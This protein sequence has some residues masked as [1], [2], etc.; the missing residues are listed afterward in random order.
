MNSD[1]HTNSIAS[2]Q[3]FGTKLFQAIGKVKLFIAFLNQDYIDEVNGNKASDNCKLEFLHATRTKLANGAVLPVVL[4]AHSKD[5]RQWHGDIGMV[6]GELPFVDLS[7]ISATYNVEES[8]MLLQRL[9]TRIRSKLQST[10]LTTSVTTDSNTPQTA[11]STVMI[12]AIESAEDTPR[13]EPTRRIDTPTNAR[14]VRKWM[15]DNGLG[16]AYAEA[17]VQEGFT[18]FDK[19]RVIANLPVSDLKSLLGTDQFYIAAQFKAAL[20]ALLNDSHAQ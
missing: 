7:E 3:P 12:A 2:M 8:Q 20:G 18:S 4:D 13:P 6:L 9:E 15:E 17:V 1:D 11:R 19:L 16:G 5:S 10:S 14:E